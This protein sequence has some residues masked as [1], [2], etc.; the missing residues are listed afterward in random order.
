MTQPEFVLYWINCRSGSVCLDVINQSWSPMFGKHHL[1]TNAY[2]KAIDFIY[3]LDWH[4]CNAPIHFFFFLKYYIFFSHTWISKS[5]FLSGICS[6]KWAVRDFFFSV[7]AD[8]LNIF[9][10]FLP[11]LLLYPNPSDPLN[12]DAASLMMKD[13]KQYDQK[14]KGEDIE[15]VYPSFFPFTFALVEW[16]QRNLLLSTFENFVIWELRITVHE[17]CIRKRGQLPHKYSFPG[18]VM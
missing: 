10:V 4:L 17:K 3:F 14:V 5:C 15:L 7:A 9:E 6:V 8:L 1:T 16:L 13:R 11:Q 2:Q 18:W 12:G